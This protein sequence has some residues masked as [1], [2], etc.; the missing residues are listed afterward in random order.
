[1][2]KSRTL[3]LVTHEHKRHSCATAVCAYD[4]A[5]SSSR[6]SGSYLG[7]PLRAQLEETKSFGR[8]AGSGVRPAS[9]NEVTS[10]SITIHLYTTITEGTTASSFF[11]AIRSIG[12]PLPFLTLNALMAMLLSTTSVTTKQATTEERHTPFSSLRTTVR[13]V[14]TQL[15]GPAPSSFLQRGVGR[16]VIAKSKHCHSAEG[17]GYEHELAL[18]ILEMLLFDST[19]QSP[20]VMSSYLDEIAS[21]A[22]VRVRSPLSASK[23]SGLI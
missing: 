15:K 6:E 5:R 16:L 3:Y 23:D 18:S 9:K 22:P 13:F 10:L 12:L 11:S 7:R 4:L 20:L 8:F 14:Q 1:M 21:F 19:T 2:I 17:T